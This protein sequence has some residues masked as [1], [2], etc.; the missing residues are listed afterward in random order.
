[1]KV[2]NNPALRSVFAIVL[3]LI[4][5]LWPAATINY[6]VIVIGVLFLVPGLIAMIGYLMRDKERYPDAAFPIEGAGSALFGL[7][8]AGQHVVP[9]LILICGIVILFDPFSV[10]ETAFILFGITSMVY[11]ISGL[12]NGFRFR[13]PK[14]E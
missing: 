11:G 4:L 8:L 6:L 13:K 12:I 3:G 10:A 5:V 7:W 14:T 1:M 2:V 9:V